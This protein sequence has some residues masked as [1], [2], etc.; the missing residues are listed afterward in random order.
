MEQWEEW[1]GEETPQDMRKPS[2]EK[3]VRRR[4]KEAR[5]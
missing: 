1:N 4:E 3:A 2:S 5:R